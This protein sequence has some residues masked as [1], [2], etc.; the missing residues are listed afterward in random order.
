MLLG[1]LN[2]NIN[3]TLDFTGLRNITEN[4]LKSLIATHKKDINLK[5][6]PLNYQKETS[7]DI[8]I[9]FSWNNPE[10]EFEL[11]FVN[12]SKRFFNWEHT[13]NN[14]E[15]IEDELKNGYSQEQFEIDGGEKGEW[16]INVKYLGN[17]TLSNKTP[18]FLKYTIQYNFGKPNQINKEFMIRLYKK[19]QKELITK[20]YTR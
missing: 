13:R 4:E 8:R 9:V 7:L 2:G 5:R 12:P 10:A 11:Q 1:I 3:R 15:R 20:L 19:N 6:I 14:P 17:R 16:I 18:T